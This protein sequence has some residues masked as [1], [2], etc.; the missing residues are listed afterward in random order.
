MAAKHPSPVRTLALAFLS[1]ALL[2]LLWADVRSLGAAHTLTRA[3]WSIRSA[4]RY[5][6]SFE[7]SLAVISHS[8]GGFRVL[9]PNQESW[10]EATRALAEH[11]AETI[12]FAY[13]P[14]RETSGVWASTHEHVV[15]FVEV[16]YGSALSPAECNTARRLFV[17]QVVTPQ[18]KDRIASADLSQLRSGDFERRRII[19]LGYFHNVGSAA[20]A[21]ALLWSLRWIPQTRRH[22]RAAIQCRREAQSLCPR[23]R[24]PRAGLTTEPCPECGH[25]PAPPQPSTP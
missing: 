15:H 14:F 6:S 25:T 16:H 4:P 17:D 21:V 5:C 9:T 11:P 1:L 3:E 7:Q 23:C 8:A 24:Y 20:A 12:V 13:Y 10:D 22:I 18:Y 2:A 19:W